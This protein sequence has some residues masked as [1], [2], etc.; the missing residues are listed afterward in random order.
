MT[1]MRPIGNNMGPVDDQYQV[2]RDQYWAYMGPRRGLQM[3]NT[4]PIRMNIG[5][6]GTKMRPFGT[7]MGPEGTNIGLLQ[8]N[9][10]SIET[11]MG[12]IDD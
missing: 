9:M 4:E 1:N 3:A 7:K 5:P 8:V 2:S 11:D 6:V 12:P 10:L